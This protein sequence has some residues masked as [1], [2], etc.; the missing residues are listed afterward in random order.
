[1]L[2]GVISVILA[3]IFILGA[4]WLMETFFRE[5]EI[6]RIGIS[7]MWILTP[8]VLF[9]IRQVIYTG[10]LRGAGDTR[11]TAFTSALSVTVIRTAVSYLC[12][13]S[14]GLGAAGVWMGIL[15]DQISRFIMNSIRFRTGKWTKIKI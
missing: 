14:L 10:S 11:F 2:G 4:R 3:A 15:A 1:M 8:V 12:A 5:E 9:Q 7:M 13:Y 6:V